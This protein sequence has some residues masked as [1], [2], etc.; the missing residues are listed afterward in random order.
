MIISHKYKFIFIKT[1][2]TAGTSIEV[3]L[4]KFCDQ[5]DIVSELRPSIK[6][7]TPRNYDGF[8]GHI[9]ALE[10]KSKISNEIWNSY[11]K[12][13]FERNPWDKKVSLFWWDH[14]NREK[15]KNNFREYCINNKKIN[16]EGSDFSLYSIDG[17]IVVDVVG[18]YENLEND[19]ANICKK[20]NIPFNEKLT[21]EK[22]YTRLV[23]NHYSEYYDH[24]TIEKIREEFLKEI[25]FLGYKFEQK[26][27]EKK[28]EHFVNMPVNFKT[29][30]ELKEFIRHHYLVFLNREPDKTGLVYYFYNI[31][32]GK[33]KS[34]EL[35][36]IFTNSEEYKKFFSK[37]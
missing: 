8:Y 6:G 24:E 29:D 36:N 17:K 4:E 20:L 15:Y 1:R 9:S 21:R 26:S 28:L 2:K 11:F 14:K 32:N 3:A 13:T 31:K 37:I 30:K 10:I 27:K 23:Q 34:S 12:F 35:A 5:Y 7:H 33:I 22:S 25:E 18:R 16:G 19:F